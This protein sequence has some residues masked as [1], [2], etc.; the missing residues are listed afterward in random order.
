MTPSLFSIAVL[1][2]EPKASSQFI[3]EQDRKRY[4]VQWIQDFFIEIINAASTPITAPMKSA[5]RSA[6]SPV[7]LNVQ[8]RCSISISAPY[9]VTPMQTYI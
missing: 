5:K 6:I 3:T 7:R 8:N 1:L 9:A 4:V 2:N